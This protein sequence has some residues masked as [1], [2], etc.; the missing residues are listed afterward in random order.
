MYH[1][2]MPKTFSEMHR[3]PE[4]SKKKRIVYFQK[5]WK[6][7][8]RFIFGNSNMYMCVCKYTRMYHVYIYMHIHIY[9]YVYIP[10]LAFKML[11]DSEI[12]FGHSFFI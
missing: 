7:S 10:L 2:T 6:F 5:I 9:M 12:F 4:R 1:L 11:T 3:S 8:L